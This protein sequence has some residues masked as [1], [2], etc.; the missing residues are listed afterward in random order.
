MN[1]C[2]M[3]ENTLKIEVIHG[4]HFGDSNLCAF[5]FAGIQTN[6]LR[7]ATLPIGQLHENS[8]NK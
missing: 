5:A 1:L 2:I 4:E 7:V 6:D 3:L 8:S